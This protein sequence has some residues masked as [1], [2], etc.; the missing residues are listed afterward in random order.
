MVGKFTIT[1]VSVICLVS[2]CTSKFVESSDS[3]QS[4]LQSMYKNIIYLKKIDEI[5][6][7][8]R[9]TD[10]PM[11][12]SFQDMSENIKN[13]CKAVPALLEPLSVQARD[14]IHEPCNFGYIKVN[15]KCVP[16]QEQ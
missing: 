12:L 9:N 5:Q 11:S 8:K 14:I 6:R 7:F 4:N 1:L 15:G 2:V 3:L 10:E 16:E 13:F